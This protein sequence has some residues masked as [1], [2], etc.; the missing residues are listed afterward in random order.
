MSNLIYRYGSIDDLEKIKE[1]TALAYSQFRH[2]LSAENVHEWESAFR[3][4]NTYLPLFAVGKCF[5]CEWKGEIVGTSF[6]IP[7][8][9]PYKWF[10]TQ[11]SY[12]RLVGVHP[13]FEGKGIGKQLTKLCIDRAKEEGEQIIALHTSEFQH[14]ARHIYES[15]GFRKK[16]EFEIFQR[17]YWIYE[18]KLS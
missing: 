16:I 18:L 13:D 8:G 12:I 17:K 9:N 2:T 10:E 1:L 7:H 15:F 3:N 4:D 14:A 5:I 6:L 11:W